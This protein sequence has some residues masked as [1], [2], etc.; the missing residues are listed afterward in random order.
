MASLGTLRC[1]SSLSTTVDSLYEEAAERL[2][3]ALQAAAA[4]FH[5]DT[6][7]KARNRQMPD[8]F[9]PVDSF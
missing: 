6:F 3:T 8:I 9:E 1:A 7:C 2:E 5:P 4:D